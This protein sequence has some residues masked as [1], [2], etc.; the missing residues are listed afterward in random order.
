MKIGFGGDGKPQVQSIS[1]CKTSVTVSAPN[2]S[3]K[4]GKVYY[5][6]PDFDSQKSDIL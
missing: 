5:G 4:P 1:D 3:F 6:I 2:D